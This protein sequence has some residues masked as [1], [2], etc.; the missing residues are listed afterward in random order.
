MDRSTSDSQPY[1]LNDAVIF[2]MIREQVT[3]AS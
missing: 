3:A 1:T 2:T